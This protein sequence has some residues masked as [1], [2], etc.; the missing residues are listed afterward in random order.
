MY[1]ILFMGDW[2]LEPSELEMARWPEFVRGGIVQPR[3]GLLL[4]VGRERAGCWITL[5]CLIGF[6]LTSPWKPTWIRHGPRTKDL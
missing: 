1:R 2:N 5:F 4:F 3:G 6:Q